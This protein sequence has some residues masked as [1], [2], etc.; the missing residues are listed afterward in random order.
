LALALSRL[1]SFLVPFRVRPLKSP[2]LPGKRT[3]WI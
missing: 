3:R 2:G 1:I